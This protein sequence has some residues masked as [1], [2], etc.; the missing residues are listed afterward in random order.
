ML[1]IALVNHAVTEVERAIAAAE[2][3]GAPEAIAQAA[4]KIVQSVKAIKLA[5][6]T[7][8]KLAQ[9]AIDAVTVK[10]GTETNDALELVAPTAEAV[11]CTEQGS[12]AVAKAHQ[13]AEDARGLSVDVDG[14]A[15]EIKETVEAEKGRAVKAVELA[16]AVK[17]GA[18][19]ADDLA[20][21][22]KPTMDAQKLFSEFP[23]HDVVC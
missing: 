16:A 11:E 2:P 8:V 23:S 19:A 20:K 9:E 5:V 14:W 13:C 18:A 22:I 10:F 7:V 15:E 4:A 6:V 1:E 21:A 12:V 3:I 17:H